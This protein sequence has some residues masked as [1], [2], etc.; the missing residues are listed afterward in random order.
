MP[1]LPSYILAA[2]G[3]LKKH[4]EISYRTY[5]VGNKPVIQRYV[6][7]NPF[8]GNVS[9]S[10]QAA[11]NRLG[12][13]NAYALAD[14]AI[15][16]RRARWERL[17]RLHNAA[18]AHLRKT[19]AIPDYRL[20]KH[21]DPT[22]E[23]RDYNMVYYYITAFYARAMAIAQRQGSKL[24]LRLF[25]EHFIHEL[26]VEYQPLGFLENDK[27]HLNPALS[28][29][30]ALRSYQALLPYLMA[31]LSATRFRPPLRLNA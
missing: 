11:R 2:S 29:K 3:H 24:P 8:R 18:A 10:V 25:V 23:L 20:N 21:N 12:A 16:A 28:A 7:I 17:M 19:L 15:P 9:A 31:V 1:I 5:Y 27:K 30:N 26:L 14:Y 6:M 13:A 4:S 22:H